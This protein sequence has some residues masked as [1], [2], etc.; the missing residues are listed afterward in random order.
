[1]VDIV[2]VHPTFNFS[3]VLLSKKTP[4]ERHW[5]VRTEGS[6]S[7]CVNKG[8]NW[9]NAAILSEYIWELL[10]LL[11]S[12]SEFELFALYLLQSDVWRNELSVT[13]LSQMRVISM[14]T[15]LCMCYS[16][17]KAATTGLARHQ[18]SVM[19]FICSLG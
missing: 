13:F 6:V 7:I 16:N 14:A 11:D 5:E 9:D 8:L 18:K 17:V 12:H 4:Y 3:A 1:M 15:C 10:G 2:G 19:N